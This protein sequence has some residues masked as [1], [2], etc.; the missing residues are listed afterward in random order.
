[1]H[2]RTSLSLTVAALA[3]LAAPRA[4]ADE[5]PPPAGPAATAL[6]RDDQAPAAGLEQQLAGKEVALVFASPEPTK[7][8]SLL[9]HAFLHFGAVDAVTGELARDGVAF[10]YAAENDDQTLTTVRKGLFGGYTGI[11]HDYPTAQIADRYRVRQRRDLWVYRL[12]LTAG[13]RARLAAAVAREKRGSFAYAFATNNCATLLQR[14]VAEAF[15]GDRRG[16]LADETVVSPASLASALVELGVVEGAPA[17]LRAEANAAEASHFSTDGSPES[18]EPHRNHGPLR[19]DVAGGYF[20][21]AREPG[22]TIGTRFGVHELVEP[23]WREFDHHGLALFAGGLSVDAAGTVRL[24][25]ATLVDVEVFGF[26]GGASL[27]W[28]GRANLGYRG[29]GVGALGDELLGVGAE[30]GP[31]LRGRFAFGEVIGYARALV[32]P[33]VSFAGGDVG[34]RLPFGANAGLLVHGAGPVSL[35]LEASAVRA[36]PW[37]LGAAYTGRAEAFVRVTRGAAI[38]L[39]AVGTPDWI[40][41]TAG[42]VLWAP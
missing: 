35:R 23:A 31:A 13:E 21:Y 37:E 5:S 29:R 18:P 27:S 4:T 20:G 40:A 11:L 25:H 39:G 24:T 6:A 15:E 38:A 34:G 41:P 26:D 17:Q 9:G 22:V 10:E 1:M 32:T 8:P 16:R 33:G 14:L 30:F 12:R 3:S 28:T 19:F 36:L 7:A 2:A 42:L